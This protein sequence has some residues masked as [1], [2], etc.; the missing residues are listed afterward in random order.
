MRPILLLLAGVLAWLP[1]S[2]V[3]GEKPGGGDT[4]SH[5]PCNVI[6]IGW[7]GAQRDH[8]REM[9]R[10][11][12][13]PTLKSL[14]AKGTLVAI[15][16]YR[17]TDTKAGWTQILTGYEPEITG[18][19]SNARYQPIPPGL[20]VF[21]R[22]EKH[23]GPDNVATLAVIGKK[24]NVDADPPGYE[25]V[26]PKRK[27]RAQAA[28][29]AP[30]PAPGAKQVQRTNAKR[31]DPSVPAPKKKTAAQ[32]APSSRTRNAQR[33]PAAPAPEKVWHPGKPYY[34]SHKALDLWVN[35]LQ[36]NDRVGSKTLAVLEQYKESPFFLFVHFA[37]PDHSG[38]RSGENSAEYTE[39]LVS[40][41]EWTG[42]ILEKLKQLGLEDKTLVYVTADHGFDEGRTSHMDA[43]FVFLATNDKGVIRRG[44]R[45]DITPTI[46]DR[47]GLDLAA[48]D[49]PLSGHPLT[50]PYSPPSW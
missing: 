23:F 31:E 35:G 47:F 34:H 36:T 42:R 7:D 14:A 30:A 12:Q 50:K 15:D 38:H 16:V 11:E 6:L 29:T 27:T 22:L 33:K 37:E 18:V 13:L 45:A 40:C 21:E 10:R 20:T 17:Q 48:I 5:P 4:P 32:N 2:I 1:I 19:F 39:G 28:G 44:E 3:A 26:R 49:P 24:G 46:L 8:V 25:I 43:P 9:L 41:D